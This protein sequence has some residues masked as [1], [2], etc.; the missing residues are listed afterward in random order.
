MNVAQHIQPSLRA[1]IRKQVI[2]LLKEHV[3]IGQRVFSCRPHPVLLEHLP[4]IAVYPS[5]EPADHKNTSPR[6]YSKEYGLIIEVMQI[7][8]QTIKG[9]E[10][11]EDYLDYRAFEIEYAL[12][13]DIALELGDNGNWI[14]DVKI[15]STISGRQVYEGSQNVTVLKQ[16][17]SIEYRSED[18]ELDN[19]SEFLSFSNKI[20]I[21]DDAES[22][23][24]VTIRES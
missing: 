1:F 15:I 16:L 18:F 19:L 17:Y 13:H 5:E 21:A 11:V 23:D 8:P 7:E 6:L 20:Q 9:I 24:D 2:V 22:E 4:C 14:D 12:L 3:D 10:D